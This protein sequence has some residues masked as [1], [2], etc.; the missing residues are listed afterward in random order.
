VVIKQGTGNVGIHTTTPQ[1]KL[2]IVSPAPGAPA[3][4][5]IDGLEA[6]GL[7]LTSDAAGNARWATPIG[8]AGKLETV[9][10]LG[11]Q[12]IGTNVYTD[13][14][15]SHFSVQAGGYHVYEIRWH[16]TYASTPSRQVYTATRFRLIRR[17]AATGI[18]EVADELEMYRD[19]AATAGNAVTF[20]L[21]LSTQAN[22][23]D[24]LSL[25]VLYVP[26]PSISLGN[27]QL[28]KAGKLTTSKVII[29]RLNV[30]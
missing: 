14:P 15:T 20:W 5:I 17:P 18:D 11:V 1:A 6:E 9:L 27:L 24:E 29:K 19:I 16:V 30:M 12:N 23:G 28:R 7:I 13:I 25:S 10:E 3:L 22:A 26:H 4:Q 21:S 8:A 2:E